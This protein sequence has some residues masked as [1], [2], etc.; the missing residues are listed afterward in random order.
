MR[1]AVLGGTFDPVH[2]GH[3]VLA[4]EVRAEFGYDRIVLIPAYTPPH[5]TVSPEGEATDAV[6]RLEML[7]RAVEGLEGMVVDPCELDRGGV[8]YTVDTLEHLAGTPGLEGRPGLIV[9][10]D[11]LDGF[12]SWKDPV[13]VSEMSDIIVAHREHRHEVRFVYRHRYAH[14][15]LLQVSSR[16]LRARMRSGHS[17]RFLVPEPALA[18]IR[19]RGLYR[20]L[21]A[22][23]GS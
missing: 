1:L 9:G 23:E 20:S 6:D 2:I 13:R 12:E 19:E 16:L 3:L 22:K 7:R 18:Y 14:N 8:S 11:L 15:T 4:E 21:A 5:K 17:V 10:D